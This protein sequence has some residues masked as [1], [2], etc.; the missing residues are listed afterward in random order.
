MSH[1]LEQFWIS[2]YELCLTAEL[3]HLPIEIR[4]KAGHR[5][6]GVPTISDELDPEWLQGQSESAPPVIEIDDQTIVV[7]QVV[8][9]AIFAPDAVR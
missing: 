5:T 1:E 9:C 3:A 7:D 6:T 2:I 8:A 4:T